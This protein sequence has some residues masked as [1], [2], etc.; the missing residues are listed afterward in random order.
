MGEIS[1]GVRLNRL[2]EDVSLYTSAKKAWLEKRL[3]KMGIYAEKF[4][5]A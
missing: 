4:L 1:G 2:L 5:P 3:P